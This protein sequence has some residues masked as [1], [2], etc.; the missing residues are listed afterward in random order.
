MQ[1]LNALTGALI[2][3]ASIGA[4][5][6]APA[7]VR[8]A[9]LAWPEAE[10]ALTRET[11]VVIP[12]GAAAAEHGPHLRLDT[13]LTIATYL[14]RRASEAAS[15]V[16]AP[17]LTYHYYPALLE[18]PGSTSLNLDTARTL[19]IDVVRSL[20]RYGPRRFYVLNAGLSAGRPLGAAAETLSN[21]GI[22]LAYTDPGP[23]LDEASARV[24]QQEGGTHADEVE[25]SMMLYIDPEAVDMPRAVKDYSPSTG[26]LRL[27]RTRGSSGTYSASG[28]AGDP[29]L[30]TREKGQAITER[31]VAIILREIEAV[32][33]APL[34][35]ASSS[36]IRRRPGCGCG[37]APVRPSQALGVFAG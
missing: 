36:S 18:Y 11:V 33:H 9:D 16:V 20:A 34:P 8:L 4:W 5:Q 35:S 2:L 27:T 32:A 26:P 25:T 22:L 19:T 13:D 29:T 10:H 28:V 23:R 12:L 37:P 17:P 6:S 21:D 3:A 7:G 30:A 1:I 24:R 31:L 14:A 15:V